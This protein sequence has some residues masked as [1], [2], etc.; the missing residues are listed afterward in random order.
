M[1]QLFGTRHRL[2]PPQ[3][4]RR[5]PTPAGKMPRQQTDLTVDAPSPSGRCHNAAAAAAPS[6]PARRGWPAQSRHAVAAFRFEAGIGEDRQRDVDIAPANSSRWVC[7]ISRSLTATP[8]KFDIARAHAEKLISE[9]AELGRSFDSVDDGDGASGR[10]KGHPVRHNIAAAPQITEQELQVRVRN[11][12]PPDDLRDGFPDAED[13]VR[14]VGRRRSRSVSCI[15]RHNRHCD[16]KGVGAVMPK[17]QT[18]RTRSPTRSPTIRRRA[19]FR[20][21]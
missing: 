2:P 8:I 19:I 12:R 4:F 1:G 5:S 13:G 11:S 14:H 9:G 16:V 18:C 6:V 20:S 10:T 7:R 21:R 17:V 15:R 3:Q